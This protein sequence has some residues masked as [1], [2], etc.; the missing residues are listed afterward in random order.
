MT[1]QRVI[2]RDLFNEANL[3]KCLGTLYLRLEELN[4]DGVELIHETDLVD[5]FMVEQDEDDGSTH[6]LNVALMVRGTELFI[7]RPLNSR[8]PFPLLV[9]DPRVNDVVYIFTDEGRLT[10]AFIALLKEFGT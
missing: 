9:W 6:C 4:L 2:P 7:S 3:L 10:D 8:R 1:Y 5:H